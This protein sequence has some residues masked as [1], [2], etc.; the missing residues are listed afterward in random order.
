MKRKIINKYFDGEQLHEAGSI[1]DFGDGSYPR[2]S[3]E[4][5]DD[6]VAVAE[7]RAVQ[8][9]VALSEI[10]G[11]IRGM[12]DAQLEAELK[13]RAA[14]KEAAAVKK[15]EKVEE[16]DNDEDEEKEAPKPKRRRRVSS[17]E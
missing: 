13:R 7:V 14:L 16:D 2:D 8:Q 17:V 5:D 6:A 1:L 3:I 4:V 10:A 15:T 12:S 9:P 11:G